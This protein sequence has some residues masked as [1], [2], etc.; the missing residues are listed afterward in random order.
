MQNPKSRDPIYNILAQVDN[1][2]RAKPDDLSTTN[3]LL[4]A[5]IGLTGRLVIEVNAM[6]TDVTDIVEN[7]DDLVEAADATEVDRLFATM[8]WSAGGVH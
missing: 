4:A 2:V 1:L 7:T 8:D 6:A 5:L 3:H